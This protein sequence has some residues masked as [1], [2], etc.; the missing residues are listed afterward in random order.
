M[1][2]RKFR[3][4]RSQKQAKGHQQ[5]NLK[6]VEEEQPS[7]PLQQD[8][9]AEDQDPKSME[10]EELSS[11]RPQ[12]QN[13]EE[14]QDPKLVEE[15]QH[16][17]SVEEEDQDPKLV[18]MEEEPAPQDQRHDGDGTNDQE[19]Q[20]REAQAPKEIHD[21]ENQPEEA[22]AH[23][24]VEEVDEEEQQPL[25][26]QNEQD[27]E[28]ERE[29]EEQQPHQQQEED[30]EPEPDGMALSPTLPPPP[31]H[32]IT[33]PDIIPNNPLHN[34][35][36][37]FRKPPK[38]KKT[39]NHRQRAALEKKLQ[40][41]K[42]KLQPI[43]FIPSKTLDFSKHEKLLKRLG[44]WDFAHLHFDR[45]IRTD[46]LFQLIVNFNPHLRCSYV[47]DFR[48]M[49]NGADLGRALKLPHKKDKI[50]INQLEAADSD[51][52]KLPEDSIA[53][54]EDFVSTWFFLHE[55][56]W[57]MPNEIVAW[58]KL[59]RDGH[60]EKVDWRRLIW[61][62]VEKELTQSS[63]LG[64]CYYASHLQCLMKAQ[65]VHLFKEPITEVY[66][67]EEEDAIDIKETNLEDFQGQEMES[68][69]IELSVGQVNTDC[70]QV[71]G[72]DDAMDFQDCKDDEPSLLLLDG[73]NHVD[74]HFL[75]R[76]N[77]SEVS[78]FESGQNMKE[79]EEEEEEEEEQQ[80]EDE[81]DDDE[82]EEREEEQEVNDLSSKPTTLEQV[83]STDL[84]QALGT[85]NL[86]YNTTAPLFSHPSGE[87]L[88]SRMD[89]HMNSVGSSLFGNGC[90]REIDHDNDFSHHSFNVQKRMRSVD[91][92]EEQKA[93]DF[94]LCM[95]QVQSWTG[96]A[97]MMYEAKN[98][99]MM[100]AHLQEQALISELQQRNNIIEALHRS[101]A[102]EEQK[103][104]LGI[105]RLEHEL[106]VMTN[107]LNGY[108]KALKETHRAFFE[109][110]ECY[111]QPDEPLYKDVPGTGGVVLSSMELEK[112]QQDRE[113]E[114]RFL[115]FT[116]EGQI[117]DFE[118]RWLAKFEL[119][120]KQVQLLGS[121]L[122]E[123]ENETKFHKNLLQTVKF[124]RLEHIPCSQ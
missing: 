120:L 88:N 29:E 47:N 53:F 116:I 31:A 115:R 112:Q 83:S 15:D 121:R 2:K 41:V 39:L 114:L 11:Q 77:L 91:P 56:T 45:E 12:D 66:N 82:E 57:I 87:L 101:K 84:I 63:Q 100:N 76:C 43:P 62:M 65:H 113:G 33:F 69:Q 34:V 36:K 123:L 98:Q 117:K 99:E 89:N 32:E 44:L 59:I 37:V 4:T 78:G 106:Y 79:E 25:Q 119:H 35:R 16:S 72:E 96:K 54:M 19:N 64:S 102:E 74:E 18:L 17:K 70:E 71:K 93:S 50:K 85:T 23:P 90:K 104:R 105:Y 8:Q 80:Q 28:Q 81:E 95:E 68:Q 42:E 58:S 24:E 108:K 111:S 67:V 21:L 3:R 122:L 9:N 10:E 7:E 55:D 118:Q 48:I 60:P 13:L 61:F 51:F 103:R 92:W 5:Q 38:R 73:R 6:M 46:L 30:E 109:Y 1:T 107:L 14:D 124:Q 40:A 94:Y 110:R 26:P 86:P 20:P 22:T 52:E 49:V 75:Q 97:R 27:Q